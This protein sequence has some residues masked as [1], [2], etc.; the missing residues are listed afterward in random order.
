MNGLN[1]FS[2]FNISG[3]HMYEPIVSDNVQARCLLSSSARS[4]SIVTVPK[5]TG[6]RH[7]DMGRSWSVRET[8]YII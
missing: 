6:H 2:D 1:R 3:R 4:T 7:L 5:Q 8:I